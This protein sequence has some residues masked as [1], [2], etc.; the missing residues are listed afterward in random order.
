MAMKGHNAEVMCVGV[1]WYHSL[2]CSQGSHG[3]TRTQLP[4]P[5]GHG[6]LA[7]VTEV[8]FSLSG[9][10]PLKWQDMCEPWMI[11]TPGPAPR[12]QRRGRKEGAVTWESPSPSGETWDGLPTLLNPGTCV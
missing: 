7:V 1:G 9:A 8:S 12:E 3:V 2:S 10:A 11:L 6:P 4:G 5:S